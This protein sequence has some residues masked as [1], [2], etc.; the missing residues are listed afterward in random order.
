MEAS[1]VGFIVYLSATF[2][3]LIILGVQAYTI[4]EWKS[5]TTFL[6]SVNSMR[7]IYGAVVVHIYDTATDIAVLISWGVL[8]YREMTGQKDYENVN[9]LSLFMPA[10]LAIFAYRIAF[11]V[12]FKNALKNSSHAPDK[13]TS[14]M[15]L[16]DLYIFVLVY[17]EFR[18]R[19]LSPCFMQRRLQL[20]ES[21][22]EAMPQLVLGCIFLVRTYDTELGESDSIYLV[23]LSLLGSVISIV[24]KFMNEDALAVTKT[25][26]SLNPTY[27]KCPCISISYLLLLLW[28]FCE[29]VVRFSIFTLLWAVINGM[30]L[31]VYL[32]ISVLIYYFAIPSLTKIK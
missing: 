4:S 29:I 18:G 11:Y 19:Y 2:L 7:S 28:R 20:W 31:P 6:K 26:S 1:L 24:N 16:L 17:D 21:S 12:F 30:F 14:I 15:I 3:L 13:C 32:V 5:T 27:T 25:A 22:F 10:V 9:M 23:F 8:T